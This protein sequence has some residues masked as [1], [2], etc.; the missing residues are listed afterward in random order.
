MKL[1]FQFLFLNDWM[2]KNDA[3]KR[4][5]MCVVNDMQCI[6]Q[7][8]YVSHNKVYLTKDEKR[9]K[10]YL[11]LLNSHLNLNLNH[12]KSASFML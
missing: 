1:K 3:M 2:T 11:P 7:Q 12:C 8:L 4:Y 10:K 6:Q 9:G 5:A